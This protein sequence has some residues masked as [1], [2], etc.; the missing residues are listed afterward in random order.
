[1]NTITVIGRLTN[2][3]E[4]K[5][6]QNSIIAHF[7]IADN[8]G[9]DKDGKDEVTFFR[10]SAF[11]KTAERIVNSY[12]KGLLVSVSGQLKVRPYVDNNGQNKTSNDLTV[13]S[14]G[15]TM[16]SAPHDQTQQQSAPPAQQQRPPQQGYAQP[17][18]QQGYAQPQQ[19]YAPQQGYGAPL[20]GQPQQG[21]NAPPAQQPQQQGFYPQGAPQQ[22]PAP[23]YAPAP[24]QPAPW[25]QPQ[26]PAPQGQQ[27]TY[28]NPELPFNAP[29][30]NRPF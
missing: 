2:D 21:Y 24:Q 27:H 30:G 15:F 6:G 8:H 12:K 18:Q 25:A 26:Q 5:Q 29:P 28:A 16:V 7:D 11:G 17:P 1:M 13:N 19:G 3:A 14:A 23:Q 4:S 22:Q 10:C 20:Q 9:K